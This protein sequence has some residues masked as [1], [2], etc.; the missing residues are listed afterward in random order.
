MRNISQVKQ[1]RKGTEDIAQVQ[2][3]IETAAAMEQS[4]YAAAKLSGQKSMTENWNRYL[5][6]KMKLP[7]TASGWTAFQGAFQVQ[8]QELQQQY[9][10]ELQAN[11]A[12]AD[13]TLGALERLVERAVEESIKSGTAG[14]SKHGPNTLPIGKG[15]Q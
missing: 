12:Q 6:I 7:T 10:R 8:I 11:S 14:L 4:A 15:K 3:N 9:L 13:K 1:G 5:A 2:Q